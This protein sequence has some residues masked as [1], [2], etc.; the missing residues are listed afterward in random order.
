VTSPPTG[1]LPPIPIGQSQ[2]NSAAK[3][4]RTPTVPDEKRGPI[5]R[6]TIGA[7][8]PLSS[9]RLAHSSPVRARRLGINGDSSAGFSG[10]GSRKFL[11]SRDR[12][13]TSSGKA[14]RFVSTPVTVSF[15]SHRA[16]SSDFPALRLS[17]RRLA[18][19]LLLQEPARESELTLNESPDPIDVI[20]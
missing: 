16:Y 13:Y 17:S 10:G 15:G 3:R 18:R 12:F 19:D 9:P 1:I 14:V 4:A 8:T 2:A 5:G 7:L 11:Q 20:G 6:T